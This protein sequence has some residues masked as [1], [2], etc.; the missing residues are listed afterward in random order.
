[1]SSDPTVVLSKFDLNGKEI[2]LLRKVGKL[3]SPLLPEVLDHFYGF[4]VADAEM[5]K[6]FQDED[7]MKQAKA[8]QQKHWEMLLSGEFTNDYF[9]SAYRIGRIHPRIGLPFLFYLSGYAQ[10]SSRIQMLLLKKYGGVSSVLGRRDLP[11]M[12]GA[13]MRAFALDTHLVLDAHFAAEKEEQETAFRYLTEGI[14]RMAS[15]DLS[16]PIPDATESDFPQR[17]NPVRESFNELMESLSEVI[18]SFQE[19]AKSLDLQAMEIAQAAEDLSHRTET[20][21]AT[22]EETAAAV[23]EITV[24][25]EASLGSTNSANEKVYATLANAERGNRVV[26]TAIQK[27]N[28]IEGSSSQISQIISIIDDI[29]FQTNLLALNAGVEAARAGESGRGFAVVASEVRSLA[30]R[31]SESASEIRTLISQSSGHVEHGVALVGDTGEVLAKMVKDITIT[32]DLAAEVANSSHQQSTGLS[33]INIGVSQLDAVT[34]QNAAMVE[35]TTAAVNILKSE[36]NRLSKIATTFQ[37][38]KVSDGQRFH[39]TASVNPTDVPSDS[40]ADDWD[41]SPTELGVANTG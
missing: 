38:G 18:S 3:V 1:M 33:E 21:A 6:F 10:A 34:Q 17:Y 5:A 9:R 26:E 7:L 14:S 15:R 25:M 28:D 22:L 37:V 32:A 13:L 24:S 41:E 16:K 23:E 20:Q 4:I 36:A 11:A 27:M 29:A 2:E 12:L 31:S 8:G 30:Q 40:I 39:Q 19:T 35:E